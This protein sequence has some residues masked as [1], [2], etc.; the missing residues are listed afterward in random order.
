M[1]KNIAAVALATSLLMSN[2]EGTIFLP[3]SRERKVL[4]LFGSAGLIAVG[5][6]NLLRSI[7]SIKYFNSFGRSVRDVGF[8]DVA[9]ANI[10]LYKAIWQI[11]L[12][13]ASYFKACCL[14]FNCISRTRPDRIILE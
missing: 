6:D 7:E 3:D 8:F 5:T 10:A 11:G 2:L 1:L 12:A 14:C 4:Q 9:P 13:G